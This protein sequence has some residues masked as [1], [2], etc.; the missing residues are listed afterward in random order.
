MKDAYKQPAHKPSHWW[1][2]VIAALD[3]ELS[4]VLFFESVVLAFGEAAAVY[5]FNRVSPPSGF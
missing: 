1:V 2:A 5:A 4:E 3:N